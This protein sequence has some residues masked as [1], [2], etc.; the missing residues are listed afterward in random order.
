MAG[1]KRAFFSCSSEPQKNNFLT[2]EIF[3]SETEVSYSQYSFCY[4]YMRGNNWENTKQKF[5]FVLKIAKHTETHIEHHFP[6][7]WWVLCIV[8]AFF[9]S[10]VMER[11]LKDEFQSAY[12]VP[13]MEA[14][15]NV[16]SE[17]QKSDPE[18]TCSEGLS[19][20][21]DTNAPKTPS[22]SA[23]DAFQRLMLV[24]SCHLVSS[25]S[26]GQGTM[27]P[28]S[29]WALPVSWCQSLA[30]NSH[31]G[32]VQ[33]PASGMRCSSASVHLLGD[34][35]WGFCCSC[36]QHPVTGF[37]FAAMAV[38]APRFPTGRHGQGWRDWWASLFLPS[39]WESS[40]YSQS[41]RHPFGPLRAVPVLEPCAPGPPMADI[42]P[43]PCPQSPGLRLP[44]SWMRLMETGSAASSW[45]PWGVTIP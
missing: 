39:P 24:S 1:E 23:S 18:K 45:P 30:R 26:W 32:D 35:S 16:G 11:G 43:W 36:P 12:L 44:C 33:D 41:P 29:S 14:E 17:V 42:L 25:V 31:C 22:F 3:Q 38:L 6:A 40:S 19:H 15:W 4:F 7:G 5:A 28:P 9:W 21:T 20:P 37:S 10:S 8:T 2:L 34:L 13:E 27:C